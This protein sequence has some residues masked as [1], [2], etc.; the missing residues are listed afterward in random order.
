MCRELRPTFLLKMLRSRA[1]S[2]YGWDILLRGTLWPGPLIGRRLG[3]VIRDAARD[4]HEIGLH[5]WDHHLWQ[6]RLDRLDRAAIHEQLLRA[7]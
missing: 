7:R 2:L 6:T 5:A 4:G 1:A 3:Q